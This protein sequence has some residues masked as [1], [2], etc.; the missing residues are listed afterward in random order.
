MKKTFLFMVGL[1]LTLPAVAHIPSTFLLNGNITQFKWD[2]TA[3]PITW[4]MNP[5]IGSN[6][7]G[8]PEQLTVF[9]A[10]FQEWDDIIEHLVDENAYA[11]DLL[12]VLRASSQAYA[13]FCSEIGDMAVPPKTP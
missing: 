10:A 3:F 4:R 11:D 2:S 12:R 13:E 7:T 1:F 6:I 8:T 9:Q 5:T